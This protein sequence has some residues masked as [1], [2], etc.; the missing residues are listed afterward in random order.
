MGN[1]DI[2]RL[3]DTAKVFAG[4]HDFAAFASPDA[5]RTRRH[6]DAIH[7]SFEDEEVLLDV[8]APSFLR[9]MV[10]RIVSALLAVERG[11]ATAAILSDSLAAGTGPDLGLAPPEPLVLMDVDLGFPFRPSVDRATREVIER[12]SVEARVSARFWREAEARVRPRVKA[13][14]PVE[15]QVVESSGRARGKR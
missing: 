14:V 12:R 7:V 5:E 15:T 1:H 9:G 3:R 2:V 8:R 4:T 11:D 10:R 13:A 6:I